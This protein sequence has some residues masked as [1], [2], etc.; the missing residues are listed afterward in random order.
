MSYGHYISYLL[1][2]FDNKWYKYDD[3]SRE[4]V[5]EA[6]IP[7]ESAY[8]L[9]Y[10]RKDLASKSLSEIYPNIESDIFIGKPVKTRD[11]KEGF[12]TKVIEGRGFE[13]KLKDSETPILLK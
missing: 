9:F 7:K 1:N 4:V 13:V 11:S 6:N 12:V 3:N 8:I 2:C 5:A 10:I